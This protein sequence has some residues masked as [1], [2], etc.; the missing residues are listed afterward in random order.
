MDMKKCITVLSPS[1]TLTSIVA[2]SSAIASIAA[3]FPDVSISAVQTLTTLPSLIA[4]GVIVLSGHLSSVITKKT[5]VTGSMVLMI[6]G[7][8]LP[9]FFHRRFYQLILASA[10][11]GLGY[12]G[13]SPLT[14]ALIHEHY[15]ENQQPRMLGFQSAVIG[16]GGVIFSYVGGRL[17]AVQWWYAYASFL[18]F[19]PVLILVRMLP[20]GTVSAR[21]KNSRQG[22]FFTPILLFYV[23][24]AV[25][26]V[27]FYTY[28]RPI[29]HFF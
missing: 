11:F 7:G 25:L 22:S 10:I 4:I 2:L 21:Q 20:D 19:I 28:F 26:F 17:A 29:S 3:A 18:F 1:F 14:T 6:I 16:I 24:Q 9:L 23:A 27:F 8:L 15:S 5:I 13:I 12:G